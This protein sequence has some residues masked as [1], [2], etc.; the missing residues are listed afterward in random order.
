MSH[1][2]VSYILS[3]TSLKLKN[4]STLTFG[5][6]QGSNPGLV[7][8]ES[9]VPLRPPPDFSCSSSSTDEAAIFDV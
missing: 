1:K 7:G 6:T 8:G 2:N 5:H 9:P 3:V 4:K